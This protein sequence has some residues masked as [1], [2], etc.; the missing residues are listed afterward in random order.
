MDKNDV[1]LKIMCEI[2]E[3]LTFTTAY[4]FILQRFLWHNLCTI[5][6]EKDEKMKY[7]LMVKNTTK[8][9]DHYIPV[10]L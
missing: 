9:T 7:F 10:Y 6:D 1:H 2:S 4:R 3:T 5:K 8:I